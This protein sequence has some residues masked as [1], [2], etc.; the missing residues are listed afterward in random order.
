[1]LSGI[2]DLLTSTKYDEHPLSSAIETMAS[3]Y[4]TQALPTLVAQLSRS[5]TADR[6]TTFVDKNSDVPQP[7]Q[8]W[9]QTNVM[10]KTPLNAQRTEYIDAWGRKDT[11]ASFAARLFENMFSPGYINRV[12][13]TP[14]DEELQKLADKVGTGVLM[15]TPERKIEYNNET[16]Y[17]TAAQ[18][19]TY[20]KTRGDATMEM[21]TD[22]FNSEGYQNDM[23]DDEKAYAVN[24]IKD[25]ANVIGKQAVFNDYDPTTDNWAEKCDGD[26]TRITNMAM[27]RAQ[28]HELGVKTNSTAFHTVILNASYLTPVDQAYAIAQTLDLGNDAYVYETGKSSIKYAINSDDKDLIEEHYRQIFPAYY[29][30]VAQ[31]DQWINATIEEKAKLLSQVRSDAKADAKAW[32]ATIKAAQGAPLYVKK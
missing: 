8:R 9:W 15:T 28:A 11:T 1:M 4:L 10:G 14:V 6:R 20:A 21:L 29:L 16:H 12:N 18:Y 7:I 25:Y 2:N 26:Q 24:A 17:L 30:P 22:L 13:T 23:S 19:Q 32:L 3:S 27:L 31:T 5:M